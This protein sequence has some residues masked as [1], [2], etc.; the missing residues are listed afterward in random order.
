MCMGEIK[1]FGKQIIGNCLL[2][3]YG[4]K[5]ARSSLASVGFQCA[6]DYFLRG[7]SKSWDIREINFFGELAEKII[8]SHRTC[9]HY[10]RLYSIYQALLNV[11]K[12][13]KKVLAV[14]VG[15]YK[16]GTSWFI[17]E[18][19]SKTARYGWELYSFDTFE[20]H[21]PKDI[22]K[23]D[24]SHKAGLFND[25]TYESVKNLLKEYNHTFVYKGRFS[26]TSK[27][28]QSLKLSFVHLDVDIYKPTLFGLNFFKRR[29]T[30]GGIIIVD[31]YGFKTCPGVKKAVDEFVAK[32]DT[33]HFFHVLTGQA[34]LIKK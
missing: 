22:S 6:P 20:G 19:L 5:I 25:T 4:N 15:V 26:D 14:E 10:D 29:M 32:N 23:E 13:K 17:S 30:K 31:D 34:I 27:V 8:S 11:S 21:N 2:S 9:L 3:L 12:Y 18:V 24:A 33:F 28:L 7:A 16:G 1:E